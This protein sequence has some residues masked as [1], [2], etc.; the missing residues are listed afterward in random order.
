[1]PIPTNA[2]HT[3]ALDLP[4]QERDARMLVTVNTTAVLT[5]MLRDAK[6]IRER[7]APAITIGVPQRSV[8]TNGTIATPP[9]RAS[10]A[11]EDVVTITG[12]GPRTNYLPISKKIHR[13]T[14]CYIV[15][16][17]N[18]M[19]YLFLGNHGESRKL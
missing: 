9:T 8:R 6:T 13:R 2:L 11:V 17:S 5:C 4:A 15:N 10:P 16:P 14:I 18:V 7:G 3:L 12:D 1:M 19:S